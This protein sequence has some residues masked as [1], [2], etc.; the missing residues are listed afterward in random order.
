MFPD[1]QLSSCYW[2]SD[3]ETDENSLSNEYESRFIHFLE[4]F[5]LRESVSTTW[6]FLLQGY[7]SQVFCP[8]WKWLFDGFTISMLVYSSS[9]NKLDQWSCCGL[10]SSISI[11]YDFFSFVV[12]FNSFAQILLSTQRHWNW[13]VLQV[14][15][16]FLW[17][18]DRYMQITNKRKD[19]SKSSLYSYLF[20]PSILPS[21]SNESDSINTNSSTSYLK[22]LFSSYSEM[23]HSGGI[24]VCL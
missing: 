16:F 3:W 11:L 23:I 20:H 19:D 15:L 6:F 22:G 21:T 17:L 7:L 24:T 4:L 14:F 8:S 1:D 12:L 2:R 9:I 13:I 10:H 18:L 5:Q